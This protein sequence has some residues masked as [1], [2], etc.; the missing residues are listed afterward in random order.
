MPTVRAE[1]GVAACTGAPPPNR[2]SVFRVRGDVV[3][4]RWATSVAPGMLYFRENEPQLVWSDDYPSETQSSTTPTRY[5]G[6]SA[7]AKICVGFGFVASRR[8]DEFK[9]AALVV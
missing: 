6:F 8:G 3:L 4:A 2:V 5:H 1:T 7:G 9:L